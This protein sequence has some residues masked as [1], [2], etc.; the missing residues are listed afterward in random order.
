MEHFPHRTLEKNMARVDGHVVGLVFQIF[1]GV[2][3]TPCFAVMN[4]T[5]NV[6][7]VPA[8]AH[9]GEA[10]ENPRR[11]TGRRVGYDT[12]FDLLGEPAYERAAFVYQLIHQ[13]HAIDPL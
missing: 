4:S 2:E 13:G 9:D 11:S 5:S 7:C 3:T 12:V 1:F 6:S 8:T 10:T